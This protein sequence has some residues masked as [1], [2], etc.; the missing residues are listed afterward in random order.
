LRY[1]ATWKTCVSDCLSSSFE[2]TIGTTGGQPK[3]DEE[4]DDGE[5]TPVAPAEVGSQVVEKL[6]AKRPAI[7]QH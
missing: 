1:G 7:N 2:L 3:D 6:D 4:L 5:D